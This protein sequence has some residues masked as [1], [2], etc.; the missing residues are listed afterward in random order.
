MK[1]IVGATFGSMGI[2]G[3]VAAVCF[4]SPL[5]VVLS[6]LCFVAGCW[7]LFGPPVPGDDD[8]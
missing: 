2:W 3:M 7:V 5:L 1:G 6:V 8:D 4:R